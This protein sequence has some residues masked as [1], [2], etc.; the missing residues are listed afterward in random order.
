MLAL[1][2]TTEA[3]AA[4]ERYYD[5]AMQYVVTVPARPAS[6][7]SLRALSPRATSPRAWSPRMGVST[8]P[9]PRVASPVLRIGPTDYFMPPGHGG[10]YLY[11]QQAAPE[12][13]VYPSAAMGQY[14]PVLRPA[15]QSMSLPRQTMMWYM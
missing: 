4:A 10:E 2:D 12:M 1:K 7:R 11:Q 3:E 9:P 15:P 8:D 5:S 13:P 14:M 6:P